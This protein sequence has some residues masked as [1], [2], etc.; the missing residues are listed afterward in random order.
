[1]DMHEVNVALSEGETRVPGVLPKIEELREQPFQM[2]V[3]FGLDE[4]P[5][6][7]GVILVRGAR[8]FGKSTWLQQHIARTTEQFGPGSALYV[9]GDELRDRDAL[10]EAIR[11]L[12]PLFASKAPVRRLFIDEITAV[13]D[14]EKALK[15][16][17]DRRELNRVL[18][19]TTGSK[20]ADLRHGSERLPG[21]KGKLERTSYIFTP[22]PFFEFKRVAAEHLK[23]ADLLPAYLLSG[24]SPCACTS[25]AVHGHLPDHVLEMVRDWI[26]GEVSASGRSRPMMVGVLDCLMRF[27]GTPVGQ[28]K[29]AR[30]A[31][32]ANNTVAAGYIDL[33]SDL[34]CTASCFAWDETRRRANRRRPCKFH[35]TNLLAASAWHPARPRR[36]A[37]LGALSE[38]EQGSLLE[39]LVAQELFRR[40][41]VCGDE[42]P[43]VMSFWQGG[44]H[45]LD[46]V[47]DA[48]TFVEVKRGK[49]SPL[50]FAWFP[51]CFP[52]GHLTVVSGSRYET[53]QICGV[54]PE[55][56]LATET[57][58]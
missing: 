51:R 3:Q 58:R 19:V 4:L 6:Q 14:W 48:R 46:F 20:A 27:A 42:F 24:G 5:E 52:K 38:E 35:V 18:V 26:Y 9:D 13:K 8:Q 22:V 36:P 37:D 45:E 7:P 10:V 44:G 12:L 30:E 23:A 17:L 41:A 50:D 29:L 56:F 39:W 34:M 28:S 15:R 16:L 40:A 11:R 2:Q 31:G 54:T 47:L 57:L 53:D 49:T 1:M 25:L 55:E 32:L 43:E 21:R 33:L